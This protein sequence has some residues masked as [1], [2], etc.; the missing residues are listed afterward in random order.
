MAQAPF[1]KWRQ[2]YTNLI[3]ERYLTP[4]MIDVRMMNRKKHPMERSR[5]VRT[6]LDFLLTTNSAVNGWPAKSGSVFT[7]P[8]HHK[9]LCKMGT[10]RK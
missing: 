4:R 8:A 2:T 10:T 7:S 6:P 3:V 1:G 5:K 9:S